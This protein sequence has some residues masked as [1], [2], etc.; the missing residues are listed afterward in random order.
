[1]RERVEVFQVTVQPN[2]IDPPAV[3][4]I[5]L[6]RPGLVRRIDILIPDGVNGVAGIALRIGREQIIPFGRGTFLVGN[7][8]TI[9]FP[10]GLDIP[11]E[12]WEAVVFNRGVYPHTF[13]LRF[14]VA[15]PPG[16]G[17]DGR[18]EGQS[19]FIPFELIQG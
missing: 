16:P 13:Y 17:A 12:R 19:I 11:S 15:E 9:S 18:R 2:T 3:V 6:S 10:V 1:M 7:N 4:P 5:T 14:L 8:E